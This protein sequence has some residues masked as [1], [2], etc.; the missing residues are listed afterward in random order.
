MTYS[1]LGGNQI[2]LVQNED[3]MLMGCFLLEIFLNRPASCAQR[4][5]SIQNMQDDIGGVNDLVCEVLY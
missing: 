3:K 4:I 1:N 2:T 5:T